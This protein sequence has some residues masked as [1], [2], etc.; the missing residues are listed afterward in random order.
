MIAHLPELL[1]LARNI[2]GDAERHFHG[3]PGRIHVKGDRDMT[4]DV[5]IAV[6]HEIRQALCRVTPSFGF[7]GEETGEYLPS[8]P[9]RWI[10]DPVDGTANFIRSMP[11]C[12]ISLA[13]TYRRTAI[14][15]VI[16]LPYL[17]RRYWAADGL[18]AWRDG[19]PIRAAATLS[20]PEAMIAVG[21][22]RTGRGTPERDDARF[23]LLRALS[24]QA[25]RL[26]MLGT[27]ALDL[28][29]V[30][31]GGLDAVVTLSNRS[32]DTAAG[33]VIA[34]EAGA[35]VTDLD[36]SAHTL[37]SRATIAAAPGI[38]TDLLH[39]VRAA[40]SATS[41]DPSTRAQP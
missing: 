30:A 2:T 6:E 29:L 18:G 37:D 17:Q 22:F 19:Q 33:V 21:D 23:A 11:L 20:L 5:D 16:T 25:Q 35:A 10:L 13:L 3:G 1:R 26:R 15:G 14:L 36:A 12:G 27:S 8:A 4:S 39:L 31:D 32:W 40:G 41:F 7:L 9:I 34:R 38:H 28:A 24:E